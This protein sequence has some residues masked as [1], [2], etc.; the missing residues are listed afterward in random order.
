MVRCP[1][2][3]QQVLHDLNFF[4]KFLSVSNVNGCADKMAQ[5]HSRC[6]NGVPKLRHPDSKRIMVRMKTVYGRSMRFAWLGCPRHPLTLDYRP[7]FQRQPCPKA[8]T[9]CQLFSLTGLPE[10]QTATDV[11][12][13]SWDRDIERIGHRLCHAADRGV[14]AGL[15]SPP[16]S[17]SSG[18]RLGKNNASSPG[19]ESRCQGT[20]SN[21]RPA[22]GQGFTAPPASLT[23]ALVGSLTFPYVDLECEGLVGP[24]PPG[25]LP[26]T[27]PMKPIRQCIS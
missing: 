1:C 2:D 7:R 15:L 22:Q 9:L 20:R 6:I 19:E 14:G 11:T 5:F 25:D 23:R 8:A 27:A 16:E 24:H 21:P 26:E 12:S 17:R 3:P 4:P 10:I 18:G 13:Y